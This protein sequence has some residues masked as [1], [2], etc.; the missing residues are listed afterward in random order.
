MAGGKA[1][2]V[3]TLEFRKEGSHWLGRCLEL[4]TATDGRS[5]ERVK[6]ELEEL[7]LLHLNGLE[8]VHERERVF[9][10]RGIKLYADE[11]P[12]FKRAELPVRQGDGV[13]LEARAVPVDVPDRTLAA[14]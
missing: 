14:V 6:A 11:L 13:L 8:D 5:L 12:E 4:G 2:V 7:V 3:L 9:R 1:F 10:E